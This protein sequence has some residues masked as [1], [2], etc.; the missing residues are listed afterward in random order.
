MVDQEH[1]KVSC[2]RA[3]IPFIE[4]AA[5]ILTPINPLYY[6][7]MALRR[8]LYIAGSQTLLPNDCL[9]TNQSF[10]KAEELVKE[11]YGLSVVTRHLSNRDF[12][13]LMGLF[14]KKSGVTHNRGCERAISVPLAYHQLGLGVKGFFNYFGVI[15]MT[16]VT[17]ET[18]RKGK[19][20]DPSGQELQPGHGFVSY[21]KTA[22]R[23]LDNGEIVFLAPFATR[24]A[25]HEPWQ[26]R[27]IESLVR[28]TKSDKVAFV[29]VGLD[30]PGVESYDDYRGFSFFRRFNVTMGPV[31]KKSE[32]QELAMERRT[33]IDRVM[34]D[35]IAMLIRPQSLGEAY[36][37]LREQRLA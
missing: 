25:L 36:R 1:D 23:V 12:F 13:M 28:L 3:V 8:K 7:P 19:N 34:A 10:Q 16:I 22:S 11:G 20:I 27:P 32:L 6:L 26:G 4:K 5:G 15:P 2:K 21:I 24:T 18:V 37:E 9:D 17:E 30:I 35:G 29:S 31:Y 33:T 14:G